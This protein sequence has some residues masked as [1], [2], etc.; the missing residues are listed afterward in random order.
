MKFRVEIQ[1]YILFKSWEVCIIFGIHT[2]TLRRVLYD[3]MEG[4]IHS[5]NRENR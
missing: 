3:R 1:S 2:T 5:W 4:R